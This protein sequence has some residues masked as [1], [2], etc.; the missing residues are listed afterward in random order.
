MPSHEEKR[1]LPFSASEMFAVV[2]DIEKYPEFVPGC[3]ALRILERKASG[4]LETLVAEMK[5]VFGGLSES[6]KS[7]VTLDRE[8]NT[9]EAC[10]I[11]GP[12]D[13]LDTRWRFLQRELG[14][15]VQFKVDFAFRNPLLAAASN[16]VFDRMVHKMTD[17]FV[18]RA[19]RL[20]DAL[21]HA[22]Q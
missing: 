16:L 11:D 18:A 2:S 10:H 19:A 5:V 21:H 14:S 17:A 6:Y 12:F 22:Q 1:I 4:H 9:V 20:H 7:K 3:A 13:H 8:K 15:E